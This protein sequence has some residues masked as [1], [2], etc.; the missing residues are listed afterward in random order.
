MPVM[1]PG[2]SWHNLKKHKDPAPPPNSIPRL[3]G[4]FLWAQAYQFAADA[5]INTIWMA[6]FDEVDE[7][8][9]IFKLAKDQSAVP[10]GTWLTLDAD[11]ESLPEDWYLK[12]AREAQKML[13]GKIPLSKKIPIK[14]WELGNEWEVNP[15]NSTNTTSEVPTASPI[16]EIW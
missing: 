15:G 10:E 14:P 13:A 5:N 12:L 8:T 6:Q 1:W 11:G 3:G 7:G 16:K 2:F 9:A 4:R